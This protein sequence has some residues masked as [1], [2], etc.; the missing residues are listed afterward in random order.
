MLGGI[1]LENQAMNIVVE[2]LS[3]D[4][5]Y[6][7][8]NAKIF[9]AMN[10]LSRR[11]QPVD[12]PERLEHS[13][14]CADHPGEVGHPGAHFGMSR[15]GFAGLRGLRA[16]RRVSRSIRVGDFRGRQGTCSKS[17]RARKRCRD[18]DVSGD[19]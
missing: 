4:D 14:T 6:S 12:D 1:L 17:L 16:Y 3:T 11:G 2:A 19:P 7:E 9:E 5:F 15:G 10:E 8:A 13:G 18:A